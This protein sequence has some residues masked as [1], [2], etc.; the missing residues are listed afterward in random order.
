[1]MFLDG[2]SSRKIKFA[3]EVVSSDGTFCLAIGQRLQKDIRCLIEFRC[4]RIRNLPA[5]TYLRMTCEWLA[6]VS[7]SRNREDILISFT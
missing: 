4:R 3:L 7:H 1:M 6:L 2:M 5:D